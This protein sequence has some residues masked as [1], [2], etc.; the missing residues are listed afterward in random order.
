MKDPEGQDQSRCWTPEWNPGQRP[1][2]PSPRA[3]PSPAPSIHHLPPERIQPCFLQVP[4]PEPRAWGASTAPITDLDTEIMAWVQD[5]WGFPAAELQAW[6]FWAGFPG[7]AWHSHH[8]ILRALHLLKETGA[9]GETEKFKHTQKK[10]NFTEQLG[11]G[12]RT[13]LESLCFI[14]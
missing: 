13:H 10:N 14:S 3:Q 5:S 4:A 6:K 1:R 11:Y 2:A 9:W 7:P 12:E 8:K